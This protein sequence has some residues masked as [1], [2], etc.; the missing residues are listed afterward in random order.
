MKFSVIPFALTA[1]DSKARINACVSRYTAVRL[2]CLRLTPQWTR[3]P[4]KQ[5]LAEIDHNTYR[6]K[7]YRKEDEI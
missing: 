5:A 4:V 6:V 2:D 1:E 7:T 3:V